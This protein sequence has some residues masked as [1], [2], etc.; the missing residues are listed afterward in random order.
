MHVLKDEQGIYIEGNYN[1]THNKELKQYCGN[2]TIARNKNQNAQINVASMEFK[3]TSMNMYTSKHACR[4]YPTIKNCIK[5]Q[6]LI[7]SP[8]LARLNTLTAGFRACLVVL[9]L[10]H[11]N[12]SKHN[13][14]NFKD[15]IEKQ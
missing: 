11:V 15:N 2:C 7:P 6:S 12:T 13:H 14:Q 5:L 8:W 10:P 4:K 1:R 9:H 3:H